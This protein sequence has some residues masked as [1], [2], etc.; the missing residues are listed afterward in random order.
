VLKGEINS[1]LVIRSAP[2]V[3]TFEVL[4]KVREE[5]SNAEITAL[6]QQEVETQIEESGLVD[7]VIVGIKRGRI[8][9]FR[10]LPLVLQLRKETYDLVAIIYS[11]KDISWYGN[12][13]LFASAIKT[14][15][16]VGVT[17]ANTLKPFS[18]RQVIF[19]D[20]F[21][22][23]LKFFFQWI[24]RVFLGILI[25]FYLLGNLAWKTLVEKV[26]KRKG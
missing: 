5:Y 20:T 21:L 14:K 23:R 3:R 11:T 9:L 12:L 4:K 17:I 22:W 13:R 16:R 1:I 24:Y 15:E 10:H 8:S 26:M 6:V 25:L 7:K 18:V 2:L 19:E